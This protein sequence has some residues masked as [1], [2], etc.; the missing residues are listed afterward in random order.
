M[1]P[2]IPINIGCHFFDFI[3]FGTFLVREFIRSSIMYL[4]FYKYLLNHSVKTNAQDAVNKILEF[5]YVQFS[6]LEKTKS[7]GVYMIFN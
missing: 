7:F 6:H 1:A 3:G 4:L 5:F 2:T